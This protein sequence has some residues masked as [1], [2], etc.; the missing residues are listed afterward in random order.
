MSL[1]AFF[2]APHTRDDDHAVDSRTSGTG[3]SKIREKCD[4]A[5]LRW[6][7]HRAVEAPHAVD[8][9]IPR[10]F[11]SYNLLLRIRWFV[12]KLVEEPLLVLRLGLVFSVVLLL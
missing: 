9:T 3:G 1:F 10:M 7:I 4:H 11:N 5:P 6:C 12:G 8:A 2:F